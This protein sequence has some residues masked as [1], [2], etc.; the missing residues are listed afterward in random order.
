[1]V[2]DIRARH[3][4]REEVIVVT[5]VPAR[6]RPGTQLDVAGELERALAH[7]ESFPERE[8]LLALGRAFMG[9]HE[10]LQPDRVNEL[11]PGQIDDQTGRLT[12]LRIELPVEQSGGGSVELPAQPQDQHVRAAL[13]A[14]R[15]RA[16]G[17]AS[18]FS[19]DGDLAAVLHDPSVLLVHACSKY[20]SSP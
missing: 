20:R 5:H 11:E 17:A 14:D 10:R 18:R 1:V 3:G 8:P 4:A 12:G 2:I 7:M 16:G 6:W 15:E 19:D 9:S 13:P